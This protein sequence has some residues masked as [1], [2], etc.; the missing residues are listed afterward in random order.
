MQIR[1]KDEKLSDKYLKEL[2]KLQI[3]K[4]IKVD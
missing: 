3:F 1:K 4:V 2:E